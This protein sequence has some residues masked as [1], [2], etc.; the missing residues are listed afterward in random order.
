MSERASEREGSAPNDALNLEQFTSL[1]PHLYN[2][3][4]TH[5]AERELT[6]NDECF[7]E[8]D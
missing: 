2:Q 3:T 5:N 4:R 1:T 8:D 6:L 7:N